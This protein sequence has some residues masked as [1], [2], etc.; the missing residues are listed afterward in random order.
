M[1]EIEQLLEAQLEGCQTDSHGHFT[2]SL[3][4]ALRKLGRHATYHPDHWLL[5]LVQAFVALQARAVYL[6]HQGKEFWFVGQHTQPAL[7]GGVLS[8]ENLL[9]PGPEGLLSRSLAALMDKQPAQ[10]LLGEWQS[11]EKRPEIV[12]LVGRRPEP[13]IRPLLPP[14]GRCFALYLQ[15]TGTVP[16]LAE[17]L[18]YPLQYCPVPIHVLEHG[19]FL[20]SDQ[21]L[22]TNH[23]IDDHPATPLYPSDLQTQISTPLLLDRYEQ[24]ERPALLLKPPGGK[25]VTYFADWC[26]QAPEQEWLV[27]PGLFEGTVTQGRYL[28]WSSGPWQ[29]LQ[30]R[31]S[32]AVGNTFMAEKGYRGVHLSLRLGDLILMLESKPG[33]DR[34][35]PVKHGAVLASINEQLKIPG[36]VLV[37][38]AEALPTDLSGLS[39]VRDQ[40]FRDWIHQ[41]RIRVET[42]LAEAVAN[43]P[44]T[45]GR[46]SILGTIAKTGLAAFGLACLDG[47][48]G[49]DLLALTHGGIFGGAIVYS[50]ASSFRHYAPDS[51]FAQH[52]QNLLDLLKSRHQAA[53]RARSQ[54]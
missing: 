7:N 19:W 53:V 54:G 49:P 11:P 40:A 41:L 45:H 22:R 50:L 33:P 15:V 32:K 42:A 36:V 18:S 12:M 38:D 13:K 47:L 24:G 20:K 21:D 1:S 23:W 17:L 26:D 3:Q 27:P 2:L 9:G 29:V 6:I 44:Q 8:S 37:A 4:E 52:N 14:H 39:L 5:T 25:N 31:A 35:L 51:W 43:P 46:F 30:Y 34:I 28:R 48:Q 16:K 10:L